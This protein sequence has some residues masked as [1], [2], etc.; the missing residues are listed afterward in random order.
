MELITPKAVMG[1]LL[2]S[3]VGQR[4]LADAHLVLKPHFYRLPIEFCICIIDSTRCSAPTVW[5]AFT[6][7]LSHPRVRGARRDRELRQA[8]RPAGAAGAPSRPTRTSRTMEFGRSERTI[9]AAAGAGA[10]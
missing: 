4:F 9:N 1:I 2:H 5:L 6:T 10:S 7:L 3:P 8:D